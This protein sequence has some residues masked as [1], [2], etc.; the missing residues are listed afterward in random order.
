[1][2]SAILMIW[3][4]LRAFISKLFP[5]ST[6]MWVSKNAIASVLVSLWVRGMDAIYSVIVCKGDNGVHGAA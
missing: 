3:N 2:M 6:T 4:K 1:A 5:R